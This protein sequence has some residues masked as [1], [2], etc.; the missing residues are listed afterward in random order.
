MRKDEIDDADDTHHKKRFPDSFFIDLVFTTAQ[1][2]EEEEEDEIKKTSSSI[3]S[4]KGSNMNRI[5]TEKMG[6]LI[7]KGGF[8]KNWKRR[9]FVLRLNKLSYFGKPGDPSPLGIIDLSVSSQ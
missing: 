9:W 6:W 8:V 4:S 1:E 2:E 7:K 3:S 5:E